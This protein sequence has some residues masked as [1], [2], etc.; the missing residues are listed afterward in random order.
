[1]EEEKVG[2][3]DQDIKSLQ[4]RVSLKL[5]R[6]NMASSLYYFEPNSIWLMMAHY[7]NDSGVPSFFSGQEDFLNDALKKNK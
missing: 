7:D 6:Y 5:S 3:K 2:P 4:G 1:V